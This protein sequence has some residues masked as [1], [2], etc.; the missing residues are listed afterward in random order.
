MPNF[1]EII[2]RKGTSCLKY[3]FAKERGMPEDVLPFWVADMDFRVPEPVIEELVKRSKHGI[4]GYTDIKD[5]YRNAVINW[6]K[7]RHNFAP[8]PN[9]LIVTPGVVF[10]ICAAIRAYTKKNDGVLICPPVYYPFALSVKYNERRLVESPLINKNG[11]Y[12]IDFIDFERKIIDEKARLFILC[13][14]HNPVGRVWKKEEL[15][16]IAEICVKHNVLII[17][18]EI[19]ADFIRPNQKHTV[20]QTISKEAAD[21]TITCTAPGKTFNLA[22]MQIS[23]IF[24]DNEKLREKFIREL[25][26]LGYSQPNALGMFAAKSA[27]EQGEVWFD[28]LLDYLE[29]NINRTKNFLKNN[30]PK[31]KLTEPEGTYL[32]WLDFSDYGYTDKQLDDIIINK[33]KLWL[34]GGHIFGAGGEGFQRINIACPRSV[35]EE[36]LKRLKNAFQ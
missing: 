7:K 19:H 3:D 33:A 10:T 12:E 17:S 28:K 31:V 27:Y 23:N 35:L 13:S 22:G 34:D 18:D 36:G 32:L 15:S 9:T 2:S 14:P 11:Q 16:K 25:C 30:L 21:I 29:E 26:S 6:F 1:D 5:D 4:F 20:F 24:I 8:N